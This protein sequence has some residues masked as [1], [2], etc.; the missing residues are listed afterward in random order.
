MRW[1]DSWPAPPTAMSFTTLRAIERCPLQWSLIRGTYSG[2]WEKA[3]YPER[4]Y[5]ATIAGRL[6][7]SALEV[8]TQALTNA[9]VDSPLHPDAVRVL[10]SLGGITVVL[11]REFQKI[12]EELRINPRAAS[13][14]FIASELVK[15]IP[16]LRQRVQLMLYRLSL[17]AAVPSQAG[18]SR[19]GRSGRGTGSVGKSLGPGAHAEQD[20]RLP[21]GSWWGKADLIRLSDE[22][23][24]ILDFKTGARKDDHPLQLRVYAWLWQ[25][26]TTV[27]PRRRAASKLTLIYSDGLREVEAPTAAVLDQVESEFRTRRAAAVESLVATPPPARPSQEVCGTCQVRQLCPLFWE[28]TVQ[29]AL[30][31]GAMPDGL[32]DAEVRIR[33]KAGEWTWRGIVNSCG[34]VAKGTAVLVRAKPQDAFFADILDHADTVRLLSVQLLEGSE[35]SADIPVLSLT[36]VSE[37]FV[38]S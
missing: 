2:L 24:E 7:H 36:R 11:E 37:A 26:D 16:V 20:L 12:S 13:S 33:G 9:G 25:R 6:V 17:G 29:A 38:V 15:T 1:P 19:P 3:G 35:E 18:S 21:D 8:L 31:A 4:P 10:K 23:C 27:N 34:H 28:P 5:M 14:S 22:S 32:R 30:A